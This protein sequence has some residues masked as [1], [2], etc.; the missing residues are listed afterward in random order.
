MYRCLAPQ[1]AD[2]IYGKYFA[3]R[4]MLGMPDP[5]F[6]EQ[7]NDTIVC[8]TCAILCNTLRA[9]RTGVFQDPADFKGDVVG[10]KSLSISGRF[11]RDL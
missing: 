5:A 3:G 10:G 8:L 1:M 6:V 2:A 11:A 7:I 9:C 4:R